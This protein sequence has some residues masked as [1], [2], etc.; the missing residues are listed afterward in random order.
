MEAVQELVLQTL[1]G[2][3]HKGK[4][5][6]SD[7]EKN[8][9]KRCVDLTDGKQE[10]EV[11]LKESERVRFEFEKEKLDRQVEDKREE[12]RSALWREK[13]EGRRCNLTVGRW[14]R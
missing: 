12:P 4:E 2:K 8:P 6:S 5:Y 1:K 3:G 14:K 9:K 11:A 7:E 10:L 13:C